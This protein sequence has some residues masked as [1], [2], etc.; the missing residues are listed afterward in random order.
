MMTKTVTGN[1]ALVA[2][3]LAL[4]GQGAMSDET[5]VKRNEA[6]VVRVTIPRQEDRVEAPVI[7]VDA[8]EAIEALH[9]QLAEDLERELALIGK[10]RTE[11]AI[12]EVPTR[13]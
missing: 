13:G 12:A 1:H 10:K 11:L 4:I 6:E 5:R 7:A 3:A 9:R 8:E 2:V